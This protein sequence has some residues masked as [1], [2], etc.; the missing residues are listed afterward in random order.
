MAK[1]VVSIV[2]CA[3]LQGLEQRDPFITNLQTFKRSDLKNVNGTNQNFV[4]DLVVPMNPNPASMFEE[5]MT[6]SKK[7]YKHRIR[8]GC[9]Y[10]N[11][12]EKGWKL[13]VN[14]KCRNPKLDITTENEIILIKDG[15]YYSFES[16]TVLVHSC[17]KNRD[18]KFLIKS[19]WKVKKSRKSVP[20]N[21]K[22][23]IRKTLGICR[24][25]NWLRSGNDI[26]LNPTS[27]KDPNNDKGLWPVVKI[28]GIS[29][30]V[31]IYIYLDDVFEAEEISQILKCL[32]RFRLQWD[33]RIIFLI[34]LQFNLDAMSLKIGR[35]KLNYKSTRGFFADN[36]KVLIDLSADFECSLLIHEIGHVIGMAHSH[37]NSQREKYIIID[38][39]RIVA[40]DADLKLNFLDIDRNSVLEY[41]MYSIMS[42]SGCTLCQDCQRQ[43]R[44]S[45]C[46]KP[47]NESVGYIPEP[48][49]PTDLD[50]KK[51]S[52][53][54][55]D[56]IEDPKIYPMFIEADF[57]AGGL[58]A[59][60]LKERKLQEIIVRS[61]IIE[62]EIYQDLSMTE[63]VSRTELVTEEEANRMKLEWDRQSKD[64]FANSN[65]QKTTT[66]N[67]RVTKEPSTV[68]ETSTSTSSANRVTQ[69]VE[70]TVKQSSKVD[71]NGAE[72]NRVL[73]ELLQ[74]MINDKNKPTTATTRKRQTTKYYGRPNVDG[75]KPA[76]RNQEVPPIRIVYP[77]GTTKWYP[78]R[79]EEIK[80]IYSPTTT[81]RAIVRT[82]NYSPATP[83]AYTITPISGRQLTTTVKLTSKIRL[84]TP[85]RSDE[86]QEAGKAV[87]IVNKL[88][89]QA[90]DLKN[91]PK[92]L[93]RWKSKE[94]Q[95]LEN[96]WKRIRTK[97]NKLATKDDLKQQIK[98]TKNKLMKLEK[99]VLKILDPNK[100]VEQI[101]Q[102]L[103]RAGKTLLELA[104]N[105]EHKDSRL[106][107]TLSDMPRICT[108]AMDCTQEGTKAL[109][110]KTC[111]SMEC[112]DYS[113]RC[114]SLKK[115]TTHT[116][117]LKM[118]RVTRICR[119]ACHKQNPA[120]KICVEQND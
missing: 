23:L 39:D 7:F 9:V 35:S 65:I 58:T 111:L 105:L 19:Y 118:I 79:K 8:I 117:E 13:E 75:N 61:L 38:T 77:D 52:Q 33:S 108:G 87:E 101:K 56:G 102:A 16:G 2:I 45:W 28:D 5:Y 42:Y 11:I 73:M 110:P 92:D 20:R 43:D 63:A 34:G 74:Q 68:L 32:D 22:L 1:P 70:R 115:C 62:T 4:D 103:K 40:T 113:K 30:V 97:M 66:S 85:K 6:M 83:P 95:K 72:T 112:K 67:I 78:G 48:K 3:V 17:A 12:L 26:G 104:D 91:I 86:Y 98:F 27:I 59:H 100:R 60:Q 54:Y 99:K 109:C 82:T 106:R 89:K 46:I 84:Q 10:K 88:S 24:A 50:R 29:K 15:Q 119:L 37:Q 93:S 51:I 64:H 57:M 18:Q 55:F 76:A 90:N 120:S 96:Q 94:I 116:T 49:I 25:N 114:R 36:N 80:P 31:P 71:S 44:K 14:P 53:L 21:E 47:K 81:T 107:Y 41:D 69:R